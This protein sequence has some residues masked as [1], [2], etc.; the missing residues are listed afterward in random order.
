MGGDRVV[1][2]RQLGADVR[3][4]SLN[5]IARKAATYPVFHTTDY[6]GL[7]EG[8]VTLDA[9]MDLPAD[10]KLVVAEA[11]DI[12]MARVDRSLHEKVAVVASGRAALTDCVYRVRV[13]AEMSTP[14]LT[15]LRSPEGTAS[16]LAATKGV[17]ARLLGKGDLLDL[18]LHLAS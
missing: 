1:T 4:G 16:L 5:T 2:L 12:L 10:R 14:V 8:A 11:G 3:R 13:P 9:A 7:T 17:S 18:P 6:R 15:A